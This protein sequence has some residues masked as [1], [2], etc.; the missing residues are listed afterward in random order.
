VAREYGAMTI[1][2]SETNAGEFNLVRGGVSNRIAER[3]G[4][5]TKKASRRFIKVALLLVVTWIPLLLLSAASGNLAGTPVQ[6][7]FLHDPEVHAR[8]LVVLPLLELAELVVAVSLAA[9]V[10]H[11]RE[12]GVVPERERGRFDAARSDVLALRSSAW[13]EAVILASSYMMAIVFRLVI[14]VSEGSSSWERTETALTPAGWWHMLVSLPILYFFLFRWI[15]VFLCWAI[16]LWRVSRLVL[17]LTPTHADRAGGLGFLG[18]GIACFASVLVPVSTVASAGFAQEILHYG[19]SLDSMK[20]HVVAFVVAAL[21][22][23]HAPL[24]A[25][26]G[27]MS[28]CRFKGLLEFGALVWRHDMQFDEK[29]IRHPHDPNEERILGSADVQSLAN[30]ATCY[31]HVDR[32]WLMPFDAKA[33][34]VLVLSALLPMLPLVGTAVPLKEIFMKLG[35]LLI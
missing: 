34:A 2:L 26:A 8:F 29:W 19:E 18:W 3:I 22:I 10:R 15:W 12:M 17:E 14:G 31:E 5:A 23:V 1:T 21:A 7:P 4:L 27:P 9:Q 32:M 6:V 33:F 16:F 24:L 30:V 13:G 20:Y 25:F 35:E 28:R 11:L